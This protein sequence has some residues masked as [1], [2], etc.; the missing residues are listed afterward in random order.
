MWQVIKPC[1]E[2]QTV[3]IAH[4]TPRFVFVLRTAQDEDEYSVQVEQYQAKP[5]WPLLHTWQCSFPMVTSLYAYPA[6]L[7]ISPDETRAILQYLQQYFEWDLT[8]Y[9][10]SVLQTFHPHSSLVRLTRYGSLCAKSITVSELRFVFNDR[11]TLNDRMLTWEKLDQVDYDSMQNKILVTRK[12]SGYCVIQDELTGNW[13]HSVYVGIRAVCCC[14]YQRHVLISLCRSGSLYFRNVHSG[15]V[16]FKTQVPIK[17]KYED[18]WDVRCFGDYLVIR[19]EVSEEMRAYRTFTV[20]RFF[21]IEDQLTMK[22]QYEI[23]GGYDL[24]IYP[25]Q[26]L[27]INKQGLHLMN[28]SDVYAQIS[29]CRNQLQQYLCLDVVN[30]LLEHI[31]WQPL[32]Y[33]P[34]QSFQWD[35]LIA[36]IT[37]FIV[38]PEG[39][40][41]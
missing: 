35:S 16:L 32:V 29:E 20:G 10:T 4:S 40:H 28:P 24:E 21:W 26:S 5:G 11:N 39:P 9:T 15:K 17:R 33:L 7:L 18:F 38:F 31:F 27:L 14:L 13:Q 3:Q 6:V 2:Y 25:D 8:T 41:Q 23:M 34:N 1:S 36:S 30:L 19:S 22:W 12:G 37:R